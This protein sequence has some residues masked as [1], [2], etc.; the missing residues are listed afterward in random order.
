MAS[1]VPPGFNPQVSLLS[2]GTTPILPVQ[3]GGGSGGPPAGYN[4]TQSLLEGGTGTIVAMKGGAPGDTVTFKN[5]SASNVRVFDPAAPSSNLATKKKF[6]KYRI[7]QY[8]V[9]E[10]VPTQAKERYLKI[11]YKQYIKANGNTEELLNIDVGTGTKNNTRPKFDICNPKIPP[12]IIQSIARKIHFVNTTSQNPL[13]WVVPPLNGSLT[14][15]AGI[16]KLIGVTSENKLKEDNQ[17]L[18]FQAPFF[19]P[20]DP[21]DNT[22]YLLL[23]TLFLELKQANQ[24][25]VFMM[26]Q[27]TD[28][29]L[30]YGCAIARS[31][32]SDPHGKRLPV[33]F[34]PDI[35]VFL[36]EKM[37]FR[38]E[39]LSLKW[40]IDTLINK[41]SGMSNKSWMIRPGTYKENPSGY[42]EFVGGSMEE[43]TLPSGPAATRGCPGYTCPD[44]IKS[45]KMDSRALTSPLALRDNF[46]YLVWSTTE[47]LPYLKTKAAANAPVEVQD[48][49][50][51]IEEEAD[52][53]EEVKEVEKGKK[54]EGVKGLSTISLESEDEDVANIEDDQGFDGTSKDTETNTIEVELKGYRL[55]IRDATNKVKGEWKTGVFTASE[56][57]LLNLLHLSPAIL[58]RVFNKEWLWEL[59]DFLETLSISQ[60]YKDSTL[61]LA[62]ECSKTRDFLRAIYMDRFT[63]LLDIYTGKT[64][65]KVP[66]RLGDSSLLAT[67]MDQF[68]TLSLNTVPPAF[69][70]P[71]SLPPPPT[72]PEPSELKRNNANT[73]SKMNKGLRL[74]HLKTGKLPYTSR[75]VRLNSEGELDSTSNFVHG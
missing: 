57:E 59:A 3:G 8:K 51:D 29:A 32:Y 39:P 2:G 56:A 7:D 13:L 53:E 34:E 19:A 10:G 35:L 25:K 22:D 28:R 67:L 26:N 30:K 44:F 20:G 27:I 75:F 49:E 70:P 5:P 37:L 74:L 71:P 15:M 6:E 18:I 66:K 63:T 33:F 60:C 11:L 69:P 16:L 17:Y 54:I 14:K 31:T 24:G 68:T 42:F 40:S 21:K 4:E 72:D 45:V 36:K 41:I 61:L 38:S 23:F 52:E 1:E 62:S 73:L 43:T 65:L 47:R 64:G 46:L 12:S 55:K 58:E 9:P 50:I 48:D